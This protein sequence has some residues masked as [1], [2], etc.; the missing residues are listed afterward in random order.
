MIVAIT[1][2]IN[3]NIVATNNTMST[4]RSIRA[5]L[6]SCSAL[7]EAGDDHGDEDEDANDFLRFGGRRQLLLA[8]AA[9]LWLLNGEQFTVWSPTTSAGNAGELCLE[10]AK[11]FDVAMGGAHDA[12]FRCSS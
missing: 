8:A 10:C 3:S 9:E 4:H 6:W 2:P 11:A 1:D 5:L 12:G 7:F